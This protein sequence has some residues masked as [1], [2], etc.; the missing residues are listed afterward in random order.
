M[1]C[2]CSALS[3]ERGS[4]IITCLPWMSIGSSSPRPPSKS[5]LQLA[6]IWS[7]FLY[8]YPSYHEMTICGY[9]SSGQSL[10]VS[11]FGV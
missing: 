2:V 10:R 5:R 6:C 1:E 7:P 11:S 9:G 4:C 3:T 8:I